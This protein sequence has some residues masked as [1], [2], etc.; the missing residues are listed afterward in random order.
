MK[1]KQTIKKRNKYQ[2]VKIIASVVIGLFILIIIGGIIKIHS[3]KSSFQTLDEVQTELIKQIAIDDMTKQGKDITALKM[4]I[5]PKKHI[6]KR[7]EQARSIAQI[8]FQN[9]TETDFYL[10]DLNSEKIVMRSET[11]FDTSFAP[12][13]EEKKHSPNMFWFKMNKNKETKNET[14]EKEDN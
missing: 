4:Q 1:L 9:E 11:D 6:D 14:D 2:P 10:I 5:M 7:K 13:H 3:F 12:M 8:S